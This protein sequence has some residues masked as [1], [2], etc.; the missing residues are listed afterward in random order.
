M[1]PI[2]VD[3]VLTSLKLQNGT[4]NGGYSNSIYGSGFTKK[5]KTIDTLNDKK[6]K[7]D[8][9]VEIYICGNP[10]HITL[11]SN[12]QID[13]IVPACFIP[14]NYSINVTFG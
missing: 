1:L 14:G 2:K 3:Y 12:K 9:E 7:D 11:I 4:V 13:F 10:A 8:L 6:D 5:N